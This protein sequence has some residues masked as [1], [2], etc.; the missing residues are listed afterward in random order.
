MGKG[1]LFE[2]QKELASSPVCDIYGHLPAQ[3]ILTDLIP[4][5]DLVQHVFVIL[6]HFQIFF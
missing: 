3:I 2:L 4:L 1:F 6:S 5:N